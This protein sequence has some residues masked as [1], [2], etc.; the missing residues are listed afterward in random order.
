MKNL[1]LAAALLMST[2]VFA[3]QLANL[4]TLSNSVLESSTTEIIKLELVTHSVRKKVVVLKG[5]G[6]TAQEI[7]LNTMA[8]AAHSL[9]SF[10]DEGVSVTLNSKDDKGTLNAVKDLS[11]SSNL[12]VGD[13]DYNTLVKAVGAANGQAGVE[14]YSGSASGN[15]TAGTVLGFFDVNTN[16]IAVFSSTN[17]GSDN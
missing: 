4:K 7:R 6:K 2:N 5:K 17:C 12:S 1:L 15:N 3:S 10:F 16:E 9:C 8:Q 11:D 13:P 14:V